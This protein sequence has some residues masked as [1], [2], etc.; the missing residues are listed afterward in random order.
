M[1]HKLGLTAREEEGD[2][3]LASDLLD[4]M[5]RCGSD[6]S[7]TFRLLASFPMPR[8]DAGVSRFWMGTTEAWT[9]GRLSV[10]LFRARTL[11]LCD[12]VRVGVG[13][14]KIRGLWEP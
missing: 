7:G 14:E 11:S 2:V 12:Q 10:C 13:T 5:H 9:Q 1:R 6:M 4:L 3:Q 8:A